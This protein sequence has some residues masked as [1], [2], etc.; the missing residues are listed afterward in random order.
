MMARRPT[1]TGCAPSSSGWE[2]RCECP[3]ESIAQLFGQPSQPVVLSD[4]ERAYCSNSRTETRA[5][6]V[7][8][9]DK[10]AQ[11][12]IA[13]SRPL[14]PYIPRC[15]SENSATD[16]RVARRHPANGCDGPG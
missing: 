4:T 14:K 12:G 5:G 15:F 10:L 3:G 7:R 2:Q 9:L 1:P 13:F 8:R 11:S 16:R 6:L